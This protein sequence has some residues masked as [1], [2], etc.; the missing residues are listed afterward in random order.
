M[1]DI[2]IFTTG[3]GVAS[4]ALQQI[5]YTGTAHI[6]IR[7]TQ[8]CDALLAEC[9]GFCRAV[10]AERILACGHIDLEAYPVY[11][12]VLKM[13]MP[14]PQ[15]TDQACLFPVTEKSF[16]M[17]LDTYNHAMKNVPNAVILSRQMGKEIVNQGMAYY[18]HDKGRVMGIGIADGDTIQGVVSCQKGAG[19]LVMKSLCGAL[20]ADTVIVE[21]AEN[22]TPAMNLYLRMGFI[23]TDIVKVWYDVT[24]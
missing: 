5:P 19:E 14:I 12:K 6:T 17:W 21:V 9:V 16:D 20:T 23:A 22:N 10:G 8:A 13:Q 1:K 2:P 24:K 18:V 7:S 4:L 11:T 15:D 3:S